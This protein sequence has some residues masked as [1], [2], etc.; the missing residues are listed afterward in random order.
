MNY[1]AEVGVIIHHINYYKCTLL[2]NLPCCAQSHAVEQ[3]Y[4]VELSTK[5]HTIFFKIG[6]EVPRT[7][8]FLKR[9]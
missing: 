1:V 9:V 7:A 8:A 5:V 2:V 4:Q 3:K 6:A